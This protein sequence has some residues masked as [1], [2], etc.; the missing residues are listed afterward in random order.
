[1]KCSKTEI[2]A[3]QFERDRERETS[4]S[5]MGSKPKRRKRTAKNALEGEL[6]FSIAA[7]SPDGNERK[8]DTL[9]LKEQSLRNKR[10]KSLFE[11]EVVNWKRRKLLKTCRGREG[12]IFLIFGFN[13]GP[14]REMEI[15]IAVASRSPP[16]D[17]TRVHTWFANLSP[18]RRWTKWVGLE[19]TLHV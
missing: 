18:K 15:C 1:M 12:I 5:L 17:R 13:F 19:A 9:N 14:W 16:R 4:R 10:A 11:Y 3:Q 7:S 6:A 2:E 8:T